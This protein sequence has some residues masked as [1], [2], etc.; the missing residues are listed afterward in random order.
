MSRVLMLVEGQTE[1]AIVEH[2]IAPSL[3]SNGVYIYPRVSGK[4]GHKGGNKFSTVRRELKALIRQEPS[5]MVTMLFDYYGLSNDWP[6][7][8]R[9]KGQK[10]DNVVK[11]L[12]PE[13]SAAI[14]EEVGTQFNPSRFIP[15]IQLHEIESLL[16][17]G[18]KEMA[19]VFQNPILENEFA[20]IVEECGGC[21]QIKD[22]PARTPSKRI[23]GLVPG[24]KK[25]AG[26]NAHAYRIAQ[27]IGIAKIRQA[28]PHFDNWLKK[29]E[30]ISSFSVT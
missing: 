8:E 20:K 4:P 24:Y 21:E 16:F 28:C 18:P 3:E 9:A 27:R 6:G 25:G 2:V 29:I 22:N 30:N 11:I 10:P 19:S 17:S 26:V 1:R 12:E 7:L 15:Y 23:I 13:I 14:A 5:S